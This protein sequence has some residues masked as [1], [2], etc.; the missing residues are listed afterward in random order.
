MTRVLVVEDE[1][2]YSDALAYMLRKEGYE[3]AVAATGPDALDGVR[4]QRR[5]PGAARPDAARPPRHG[6]VPPDPGRRPTCR[7]SWSPPRTPRS[8]RWSGWSWAPTTT[9]PSRSPRASWW[10]GSARCSGAAGEP[11]TWR[12][13]R[14]RRGRS[15]STWSGTRSRSRVAEQ[16][17]PLKEFELLEILLRNP[18]RVLTRGQLI[19]RVWGSDYVGDTK[20]L[21]VHVKR[22]RAK[23]EPDPS[24]AEVPRHRPRARLQVRRLSDQPSTI[25]RARSAEHDQPSS[26]NRAWSTSSDAL[27]RH[28]PGALERGGGVVPRRRERLAVQPLEDPSGQRQRGLRRWAAGDLQGQ[29]HQVHGGL[30]DQGRD[31][32]RHCDDV[33]LG[34]HVARGIGGAGGPDRGTTRR[35]ASGRP[36]PRNRGRQ[37]RRPARTS[38][39]LPRRLPPRGGTA[40]STTPRRRPA[41]RRSGWRT[42]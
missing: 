33:P 32:V 15:G 10:P 30:E 31:E 18:G 25:S 29:V 5:R 12:R 35:Y 14:W 19:D 39:A 23:V 34:L 21:D 41:P 20:T 9:S 38:R 40:S 28:S 3:V 27:Q 42:P 8:T 24:D 4:P 17:L 16:R 11:P 1:E 7:S 37:R 6:G 2:S 13:R 36:G 26:G 22:L